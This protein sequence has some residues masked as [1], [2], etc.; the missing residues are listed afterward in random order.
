MSVPT[1]NLRIQF[2]WHMTL[3]NWIVSYRYFEVTKYHLGG[4]KYW[5]KIFGHS[6]PW[7]HGH[8]SAS[9]CWGLITQ[10]CIA[11]SHKNYIISYIAAKKKKPSKLTQKFLIA[12]CDKEQ[13]KLQST[14]RCHLL[15]SSQPISKWNSLYLPNCMEWHTKK[16]SLWFHSQDIYKYQIMNHKNTNECGFISKLLYQW[17][18]KAISRLTL[19]WNHRIR[20]KTCNKMH[21]LLRYNKKM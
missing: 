7:R 6:D 9:K 2:F 11:P 16:I 21:L 5:R 20:R 19:W 18:K 4:S 13:T 15:W 3:C 12:R 14:W 1:D 10:G 8:Y 17:L